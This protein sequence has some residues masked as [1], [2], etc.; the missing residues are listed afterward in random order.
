MT[1]PLGLYGKLPSQGDFVSRRLPW[2]F[3]AAWDDWLQQGLAVANAAD[4][5]GWLEA[6]LSAPIWRFQLRPGIAGA[7]GW[8]GVWMPSVD[9]VGRH[10]PLTLAMPLDER[11]EDRFLLLEADAE[12]RQVEDLALRALDPG[13][14][15][16]RFDA[17]VA[18]VHLRLPEP[19]Q[20]PHVQAAPA[21]LLT[22]P[23]GAEVADV[24]DAVGNG[25]PA[26]ACF[27]SRGGETSTP[28]LLEDVALPA[29]SQF[30]L[31]LRCAETSAP[32]SFA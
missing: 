24:R 17:E 30:T 25:V 20:V 18:G 3:I 8:I 7:Q 11:R 14:A 1:T 5:S 22:F 19:V 15:F 29:A 16:E 23:A 4:P 32:M 13:L 6:Y 10:F 31:C 9:R 2:D 12:F 21:R 28:T 26:A 27:F